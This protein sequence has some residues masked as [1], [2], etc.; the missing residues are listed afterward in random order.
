MDDSMVITNPT[1]AWFR[2]HNIPE[3]CTEYAFFAVRKWR[4]DYA[5]PA[6][7]IALEV[8]GGVFLKGGGRH[9]RGAGF[10]KD[11]EKYNAATVLGWSVLRVLPQE[12]HTQNTVA[13]I[14]ALD[15]DICAD[16]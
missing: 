11:L 15:V 10:R 4:F 1:L 2:E 8:E 12:L 7:M 14:K 16:V 9:N 13:M 3:P 6:H 5:W